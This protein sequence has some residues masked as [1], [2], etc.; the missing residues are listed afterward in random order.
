M[1]RNIGDKITRLF[2]GDTCRIIYTKNES[3]KIITADGRV[4][5]EEV[6]VPDGADYLVVS[7]DKL[8]SADKFSPYYPVTESELRDIENKQS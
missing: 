4:T 1:S 3:H 5:G 2:D 8:K 7:L 6:F